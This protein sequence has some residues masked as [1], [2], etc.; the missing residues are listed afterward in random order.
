MGRSTKTGFLSDFILSLLQIIIKQTVLC[1]PGSCIRVVSINPPNRIWQFFTFIR[2]DRKN[3]GKMWVLEL[4]GIWL[5]HFPAG[6][7]GVSYTY[8]LNLI[9]L[10]YKMGHNTYSYIEN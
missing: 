5:C 8:C 1:V 10:I 4:V 3:S 9:F 2:Y 7:P 6:S